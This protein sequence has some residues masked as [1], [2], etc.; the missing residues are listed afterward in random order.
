VEWRVAMKLDPRS[1]GEEDGIDPLRRLEKAEEES[2]AFAERTAPEQRPTIAAA[3][4][5]GTRRAYLAVRE[6]AGPM[7]VDRTLDE[8]IRAV[9]AAVERGHV[10]APD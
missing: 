6:L 8:D 9:R 1:K 5:E 3:L 10:V 2:K 7:L 4:G